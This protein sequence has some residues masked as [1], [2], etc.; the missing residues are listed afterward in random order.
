MFRRLWRQLLDYIQGPKFELWI[1]YQPN[2]FG[3]KETHKFTVKKKIKFGPKH[4]IFIDNND[5]Q[6]EIK[7]L[8]PIDYMIREYYE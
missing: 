7:C 2:T 5:R 4:I 3:E 6:V 8:E 1:S